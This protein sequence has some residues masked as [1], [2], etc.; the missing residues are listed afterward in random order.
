MTPSLVAGTPMTVSP[1]DSQIKSWRVLHAC[2]KAA[3]LASLTEAQSVVGMRPQVLAREFWHDGNSS[4]LSLM[5]AWHAVRDWRHA[6]NETEAAAQIQIVHAHSFASAM[7]AV[8]GSIPS[9]YDF[10][11]GL[12]DTSVAH[13]GTSAGPWL[14]RSFR[15]AEQFALSRAGA[16]VTHSLAMHKIACERGAGTNNVFHVPEPVET[17]RLIPDRNWA[18]LHGIDLGY[19]VVLFALPALSGIE[20]TLQAFARILV[21]IENAVLLFELGDLDRGK[22]LRLS[23]DLEVADNIR[24]ISRDEHDQATACAELVLVPA[25]GDETRAN[26]SMLRAMAAGKAVVAA[27]V[28]ENRECSPD[29]RG[30]IWYREDD[31]HDLAQ[32]AAFVARNAEFAR[33]L[34]ESGQLHLSSTRSPQIVGRQYDEVYRHAHS[35]RQDGV[36]KISVP[37][38][39]ALNVQV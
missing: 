14:L 36:P 1:S 25:T 11:Q 16:V 23:R 5:T 30:V 10:S 35:R 33:S 22:L 9:A 12:E 31:S 37:K 3:A 34:G 38:L 27:D 8:R 24:C 26:A 15:V 13:E 20:S 21:E 39:Y 17:S 4:P 29:G 32:R 2:E 6:L 19:D 18:A 7:A 28:P